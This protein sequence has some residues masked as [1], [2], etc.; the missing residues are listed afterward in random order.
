MCIMTSVGNRQ[1]RNYLDKNVTQFI[2][3]Y[4]DIAKRQMHIYLDKKKDNFI[5]QH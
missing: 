5:F 1:L 4:L 3:T 2:K